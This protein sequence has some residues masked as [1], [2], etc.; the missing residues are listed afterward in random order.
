MS[1][2]SGSETTRTERTRVVAAEGGHRAL[3]RVERLGEVDIGA[4]AAP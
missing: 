3:H 2:V 1:E 4:Q